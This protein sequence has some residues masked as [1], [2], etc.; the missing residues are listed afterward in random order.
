MPRGQVTLWQE[1]A[2]A[3]SCGPGTLLL[4]RRS[5]HSGRMHAGALPRGRCS[6]HL[7]LGGCVVLLA[8]L[9]DVDTLQAAGMWVQHSEGAW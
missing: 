6:P 7:V 8:E 9:H 1:A 3:D 2:A 5:T 4:G